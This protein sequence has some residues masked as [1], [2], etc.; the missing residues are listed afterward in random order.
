VWL[1]TIEACT[2]SIRTRLLRLARRQTKGELVVK[3]EMNTIFKASSG[4][5]V[6]STRDGAALLDFGKGICCNI[7]ATGDTIWKEITSSASGASVDAILRRLEETFGVSRQDVQE[8]TIAY[9]LK[10]E[11]QGLV[12]LCNADK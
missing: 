9:L 12:S 8:D 4:V 1:Q 6:I 5:R 10:L 3:V 7:D 2:N 11:A